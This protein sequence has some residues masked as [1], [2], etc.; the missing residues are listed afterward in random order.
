MI[1][2]SNGEK[3][4]KIKLGDKKTNVIYF[5]GITSWKRRKRNEKLITSFNLLSLKSYVCTYMLHLFSP[6][7]PSLVS[8][9]NLYISSVISYHHI[10][11]SVVQLQSI[12]ISEAEIMDFVVWRDAS[13]ES[14]L[15][16]RYDEVIGKCQQTFR[17]WYS[18]RSEFCY[19]ALLADR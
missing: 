15:Q 14:I 9:S 16:L 7:P 18:Q 19:L 13:N 1:C 5:L 8:C 12:W 3:N 2:R 10:C 6:F 4:R 17:L 11:Q